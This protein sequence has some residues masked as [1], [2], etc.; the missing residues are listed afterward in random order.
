M[1]LTTPTLTTLLLLLLPAAA[2]AASLTL[3][4]PAKPNPFSLPPSTH[5]TLSTLGARASAPLSAVNTFVFHNVSAGSYLVDVH[6]QT[7]A[8]H[9]LRLDVPAD[10]AGPLQA[11]ETYRGNDWAN[12]GEAVPVRDGSA[13]RGVDLRAL[14]S[15]SYFMERP[16]FSVLTIL[17]NPMI[18]MGLVSMGIFIGMPYLMDNMDPELRAEFEAH[19]KQGPMSAVMGGGQSGADNP[20]GN[21]DMAAYLAGSNKK[22]S[23]S[24]SPSASTNTKKEQGVRR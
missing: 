22:D 5:A 10:A 17:K 14:G 16:T 12:K 19:Q 4:L 24:G 9:P 3:Y 20:L 13:G 1:H 2:S 8:F 11:W 21:F 6:C 23:G 7:D 15:K 18:L